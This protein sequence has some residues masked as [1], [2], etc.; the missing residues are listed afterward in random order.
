[1]LI[2]C[3]GLGVVH[4]SALI[5]LEGEADALASKEKGAYSEFGDSLV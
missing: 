1:M 2:P 4:S 3:S 5:L